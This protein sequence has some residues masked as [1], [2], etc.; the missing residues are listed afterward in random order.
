MLQYTI[1]RS[2]RRRTIGIQVKQGQVQVRAPHSARKQDIERLVRQ[3][4]AWIQRHLEHQQSQLRQVQPRHWAQGETLWWLGQPLYL[5]RQEA[6]AS[7]CYLTG[8]QLQVRLGP[9]VQHGDRRTRALVQNWYQQQAWSWLHQELQ[10]LPAARALLSKTRQQNTSDWLKVKSFRRRWGACYQDGTIAL[11]WPLFAAPPAV[12]RYVLVHEL[13]H[14]RYFDHS[15]AFWQLVARYQPDFR[16]QEH[17]L[18]TKG[19]LLLDPNYFAITR[20]PPGN[21]SGVTL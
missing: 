7:N 4:A 17:W 14:L 8:E 3:Q 20:A 5:N 2:A 11:A 18:K 21:S 19:S 1:N 13:C 16:S 9:Q 12:V 10:T 15:R 6:D